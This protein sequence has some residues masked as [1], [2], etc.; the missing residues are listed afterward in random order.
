MTYSEELVIIFNAIQQITVE[1]NLFLGFKPIFKAR[2]LYLYFWKLNQGQLRQI[3]L[4]S[5]RTGN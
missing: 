1:I 5:L 3:Q 2:H 4:Q